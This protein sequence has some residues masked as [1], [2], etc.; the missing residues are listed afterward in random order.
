MYCHLQFIFR[1][2]W[3]WYLLETSSTRLYGELHFVIRLTI[4]P[5]FWFLAVKTCS[6]SVLMRH[7]ET[8]KY[9]NVSIGLYVNW[10]TQIYPYQFSFIFIYLWSYSCLNIIIYSLDISNIVSINIVTTYKQM[11]VNIETETKYNYM[12]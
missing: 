4:Y 9:C 1:D 6:S 12:L 7:F 5:L 3:I 2:L 8:V 11:K 10:A